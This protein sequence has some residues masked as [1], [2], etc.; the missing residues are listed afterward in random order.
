M[1]KFDIPYSKIAEKANVSPATVSRALCQPR[2]VK[3]ETLRS[4]YRA[5]EELGGTLPESAAP[6]M[7][8][9]RILAVIPVINNPFYTDLIMGMQDAANQNGCQL[10]FINETISMSNIQRIIQMIRLADI[11]GIIITQRVDEQILEL[12]SARTTVIQC[13]EFNE[14]ELVSYV[15]IDNLNATKKLMRYLLSTGKKRIALVNNDPVKYTYA[16]LRYQGYIE[17]LQQAGITPDPTHV[18]VVSD[19]KFNTA[20]SAVSAM[21][22]KSPAPDA[23]FCV[24]DIMAAAALRACMLEN[25]RVPQDIYIAGFDNVDISVMTTPNITTVNQP[26]YDMGFTAFSQLLTMI[27]SPNSLTQKFILETELILRESTDC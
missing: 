16:R 6:A 14:S 5:I 3:H 23:I 10:L 22:K 17:T 15:T 9:I 19:G 7:S 13:S 21:L 20:V 1:G 12:L 18:L 26:R 8:D 25:Y 11:S 2:L 4:I 27:A 24:S